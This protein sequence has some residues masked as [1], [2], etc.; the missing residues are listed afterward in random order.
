MFA[1]PEKLI[2]FLQ[3]GGNQNTDLLWSGSRHIVRALAVCSGRARDEFVIR[4]GRRFS[5]RA[6]GSCITPA[7]KTDFP[8]NLELNTPIGFKGTAL[9]SFL[10]TAPAKSYS[11]LTFGFHH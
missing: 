11:V 4:E 6:H 8:R 1:S 10:S 3:R 9:C 5:S 2:T 7:G